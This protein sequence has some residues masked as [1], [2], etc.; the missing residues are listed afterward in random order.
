MGNNLGEGQ[1]ECE[2]SFLMSDGKGLPCGDELCY[3]TWPQGQSVL[4][5]LFYLVVQNEAFENHRGQIRYQKTGKTTS[6]VIILK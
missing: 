3:A 4:L 1:F 2:H 6:V 5:C